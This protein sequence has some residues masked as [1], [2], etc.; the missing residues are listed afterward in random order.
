MKKPEK[1]KGIHYEKAG[2]PDYAL[3]ERTRIAVAVLCDSAVFG[4]GFMC[5]DPVFPANRPA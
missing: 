4:N 3:T 5:G 1:Q 2:F